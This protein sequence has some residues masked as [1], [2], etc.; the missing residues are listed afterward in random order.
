LPP[1]GDNP[2]RAAYWLGSF[3]A[4]V[5]ALLR[6][7]LGALVLADLADRLRDFHA[8]YTATGI[9]AT[10]ATRPPALPLWSVFDATD[11]RAATL[12]LFLS[13][14][15]FA[16][17]FMAGYRTRLATTLLWIFV[18]SLGQR[19]PYVSDGGDTV[20]QALLFWSLFAD[21][22]ARYS[23]DVALGR[24]PRADAVPAGPLRMLQLQVALVYLFTFLAKSGPTWWGGHAVGLAVTSAD[25]GRGLGPL[26]ARHSGVCAALTYATLAIEAA[27]PLL[28][29]SPWRPGLTRA[30]A[31]GAGL[32]LHGGIFLTMRVGVFSQVMPA[33]YLLFVRPSWIDAAAAR[34]GAIVRRGRPAPRAEP[35]V[36]PPHAPDADAASDA[37]ARRRSAVLVAVLGAQLALILGEQ[38]ARAAAVPLPAP[39]AWQLALVGQRQNWGMFAPDAP[40]LDV[41]WQ[42]PG[43]LRDG[44]RVDLTHDVARGLN[45]RS[46][47]RY[48][49]WH[50]LRNMMILQ[51]RELLQT[52]GRYLCRRADGEGRAPPLER[53]ELRARIEPRFPPGPTRT[54]V[55]LRQACGAGG[56]SGGKGR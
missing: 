15:L 22:G 53:F 36:A 47:F 9:V 8:F 7:A 28:A 13:G 24:R 21:L 6:I 23:L 41:T 44:T 12:A 43:V 25:W 34:L 35:P 30:V 26:L 33:S 32:A 40:T 54:E 4:R 20:V 2:F 55:A 51:P 1:S 42:A 52:V 45:E 46:G 5:G 14:F 27:F 38:L 17:A 50:R 10:P 31:I 56:A 39:I 19:N 49:R 37:R 3:D 48:S 11:G 18:V 16:A 29:L